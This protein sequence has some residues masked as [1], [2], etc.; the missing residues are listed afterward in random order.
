MLCVCV[1]GLAGPS[2]CGACVP[3]VR[4]LRLGST[5]SH[6]LCGRSS[7]WPLTSNTHGWAPLPFLYTTRTTLSRFRASVRVTVLASFF[8]FL[9]LY[10]SSMGSAQRPTPM[11]A[12]ATCSRRRAHPRHTRVASPR[13]DPGGAPPGSGGDGGSDL[14]RSRS[15]ERRR[16]ATVELPGEPRWCAW[17]APSRGNHG[18]PLFHFFSFLLFFLQKFLQNIFP[19]F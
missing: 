6:A 10:R 12:G 1:C 3:R 4:M 17:R 19:K 9:L 5:A 11:G 18:A 15:K 7:H 2:M 13:G 16:R 8:F 14:P